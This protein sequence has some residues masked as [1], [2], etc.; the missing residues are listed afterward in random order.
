MNDQ[1]RDYYEIL[2]LSRTAT[3]EEVKSAYR[4][5]ALK[6]HPDRNSDKQAEDKFKEATE[7][8][9]ILSDQQ[10]RQQ[11][12]QY[13]HSGVDRSGM[14]DFSHMHASDIFSMF[15]DIFGT[16]RNSQRG[17]DVQVIT[18]ISLEEAALGTEKRVPYKCAHYC[19]KCKGIGGSGSIC[20]T[21]NGKGRVRMGGGPF[22]VVSACPDCH[23]KTVVIHKECA[24]CHGN[25]YINQS[26]TISL[27]IPPG[28]EDGEF[29]NIQGYG[30]ANKPSIPRGNL[31]VQVRITEHERFKRE[32]RHLICLE[33]L[34]FTDVCLGTTIEIETLYGKKIELRVPKGTQ[35]GQVFRL[36]GHG[37]PSSYGRGDMYVQINIGVPTNLSP[38]AISVLQEFERLTKYN[39][40]EVSNV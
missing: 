16:R 25:G 28:I 12:D 40:A 26:E 13:G 35:F 38:E 37:M 5:K 8:Y 30:H 32:D 11:Y 36:P 39:P 18:S 3:Q 23:G 15:H 1:K 9:E 27:K 24:S 33:D 34:S 17:A 19:N 2:E 7:A 29:L 6:F 10:K 4:R 20:Q 14:H 22:S 31:L 21:C